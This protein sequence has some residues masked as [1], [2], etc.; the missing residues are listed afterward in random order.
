MT[1]EIAMFDYVHSFLCFEDSKK[2]FRTVFPRYE[3]KYRAKICNSQVGNIQTKKFRFY[4]FTFP[5]LSVSYCDGRLCYRY[6]L[7]LLLVLVLPPPPPPRLL[8]LE[9]MIVIRRRMASNIP[10]MVN[11][12]PIIAKTLVI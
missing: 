2:F 7:L 4:F 11:I 3:T 9:V 12:P 10:T 5:L 1:K 8:L 6:M